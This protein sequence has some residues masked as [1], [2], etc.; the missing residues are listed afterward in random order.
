MFKRQ[1]PSGAVMIKRLGGGGVM[2]YWK[3]TIER[4]LDLFFP[5]RCASCKRSSQI[6]CSTCYTSIQL[7]SPPFC[8]HCHT[9][10]APNN[11]CQ[12]CAY[13]LLRFSGLRIVGAYQEPLRSCIHALKYSG[14]TR[15]A[16]PLGTLL[17]QTYKRTGLTADM[18]IPVPLHTERQQQR[19]YNQAQLLA[20][21]CSAELGIPLYVSLLTRVRATAAQAHL[22]MSERQQ[23]V[24]GAFLLDP[25]SEVRALSKSNILLIDDVCTTGAT[26][27]ACAAPLFAAGANNVWGLVLARPL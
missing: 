23:N 17:A 4:F 18:I 26:L 27:E 6:L 25:K 19:G 24:A 1:G 11:L 7:L 9:P 8:K 3:Q 14:N 16:R 12:N 2:H 13:H 5:P 15:L 21:V 20:E 10:L 22:S